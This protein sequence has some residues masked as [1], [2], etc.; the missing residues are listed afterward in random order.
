MSLNE[1]K[2]FNLLNFILNLILC[3]DCYSPYTSD[4]KE[5]NIDISELKLLTKDDLNKFITNFN[6]LLAMI[7]NS[8]ESL[9]IYIKKEE[10]NSDLFLKDSL[11]N[12]LIACE[13]MKILINKLTLESNNLDPKIDKVNI[14]KLIEKSNEIITI[15][16]GS[17]NIKYLIE[18]DEKFD[19][20]KTY[21]SDLSWLSSILMTFLIN[22]KKYTVEGSITTKLEN[23]DNTIRIS[24]ID[25][26]CGVDKNKVA[27]LFKKKNNTTNNNL[28]LIYTIIEKLNGTCG[29]KTNI[30]NN[31]IGSIFWIEIPSITSTISKECFIPTEISKKMKIIIC[32]DSKVMI[33][34]FSNYIDKQIP[35]AT[36]YSTT[37]IHELLE[38]LELIE[39][40]NIIIIILDILLQNDNSLQYLK[41]IKIINKNVGI[42]VHTGS[43]M[44]DEEIIKYNTTVNLPLVIMHKP[45]SLEIIKKNT[46]LILEMMGCFNI[47]IIDSNLKS[48]LFIKKFYEERSFQIYLTD[49]L[50]DARKI[51]FKMN[52]FPLI[53]LFSKNIIE[54]FS[55]EIEQEFNYINTSYKCILNEDNNI[56]NKEKLS[57]KYDNIITKIN[58][59][60]LNNILTNAIEKYCNF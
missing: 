10:L 33:E 16:F 11:K 39:P 25:T 30:Y 14:I 8:I 17:N 26:G 27:T 28:Y 24:V 6:V 51:L 57:L 60:V 31:N 50:I 9:N 58:N 48:S 1:N 42:I 45:A 23:L 38:T 20:S 15:L 12:Q 4:I 32:D 22:A 36:T 3:K 40:N 41:N 44:N 52:G 54:S 47:F 21:M 5:K 34:I 49:N 56:I 2:K 55:Q 46:T 29:Y 37:N 43:S 18:I 19:K 13:L 35:N 59:N 7:I 53:I